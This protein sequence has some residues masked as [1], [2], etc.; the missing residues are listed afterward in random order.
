M[1]SASAGYILLVED[2]Q[3]IAEVFTLILEAEGYRVVLA[4]DGVDALRV[5]ETTPARPSLILTDLMMPRMSG[6]ELCRRLAAM[7]AYTDVPVV[8]VSSVAD[9][10]DLPRGGGVKVA[11][12]KPPTI[13]ELLRC[14]EA[15]GGSARRTG[16]GPGGTTPMHA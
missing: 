3:E 14:V 7:P 12:P 5:L 11:F 16:G 10:D 6:F 1:G 13:E 9:L 15:W 4:C 2:E 8:V